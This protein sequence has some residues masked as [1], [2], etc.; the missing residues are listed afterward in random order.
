MKQQLR[1]S[2]FTLIELMIVVAIIGIIAAIAVPSF[3]KSLDEGRVRVAQADMVGLIAVIEN[4]YQ[5]TLTYPSTNLDTTS[6]IS[7]HFKGWAPASEDF[8][9][10]IVYGSFY[11]ITAESTSGRT[12]GCA[13]M[14]DDKNN[15]TLT[16][17]NVGENGVWL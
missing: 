17:C 7:G 1:N 2:G 12:I 15:R 11:S 9:F 5:K 13:L 14:L 3:G 6:A 8:D 10:K 16:T 4:E